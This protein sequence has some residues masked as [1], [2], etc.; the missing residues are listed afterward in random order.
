MQYLPKADRIRIRMYGVIEIDVCYQ[1]IT[2]DERLAL[3]HA[4]D[5]GNE[6]LTEEDQDVESSSVEGGIE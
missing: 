4:F 5:N 3:S 1:G 2:F 6:L